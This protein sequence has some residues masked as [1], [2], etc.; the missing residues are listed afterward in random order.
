MG[1]G[2]RIESAR[3]RRDGQVGGCRNPL[4]KDGTWRWGD[5]G[6]GGDV[7]QM[8]MSFA[9]NGDTTLIM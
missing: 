3:K 6:L 1:D 2:E 4:G 5:V 9:A 8:A 7:R